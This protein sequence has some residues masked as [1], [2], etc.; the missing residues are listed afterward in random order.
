MKPMRLNSVF[1]MAVTV[2]MS[3]AA[4]AS[5]ITLANGNSTAVID[6][7]SPL[8]LTG[9]TVDGVSQAN[10]Q[11]FWFRVGTLG[12]ESAASTVTHTVTQFSP[13]SLRVT[14]S[15]ALFSVT[16]NYY[17]LGGTNGSKFSDIAETVSIQNLSGAALDFHLF[18]YTD[19]NLGGV[20]TGDSLWL[21]PGTGKATQWNKY[22]QLSGVASITPTSYQAALTPTLA[23]SL[24]DAS[25]TL[26][27]NS[28]GPVG[29]GDATWAYEWNRTLGAGGSMVFSLDYTISPIPEPGTV[30]MLL[31]GLGGL[32]VWRRRR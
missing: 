8:G 32:G 16:T 15:N 3:A 18:Q 31:L 14:Y 26:L 12:P 27:T 1:A 20:A 13:D 11:S 9:W 24:A 4:L 10:T 17:L 7:D 2:L 29:P 19:L 25:P 28:P 23:A 22:W 30:A 6:P 5:P 21:D